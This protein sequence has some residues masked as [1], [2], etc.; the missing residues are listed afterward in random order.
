[1]R[2]SGLAAA[3]AALLCTGCLQLSA[4]V[5]IDGNGS[6]TIAYNI[7]LTRA[8]LAQLRQLAALG[9]GS[10]ADPLSEE[11]L[12]LAAAAMG[13]GVSVVSVTSRQTETTEGR[14]VVYA[15]ADINQLRINP[16]GL[17]RRGNVDARGSELAFAIA[18]T[19][20]AHALL[21]I[22]MPL[23]NLPGLIAPRPAGEHELSPERLAELR[24]MYAGM[25]LALAVE[26]AGRI[27]GATSL[28][29]DGRRVTLIDLDFDRLLA[30]EHAVA[31]LQSAST[32]DA[33][34]AAL[35]DVPGAKICLDREITIEFAPD[36]P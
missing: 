24:Q 10:A 20:D 21:R 7:S 15:F 9:G 27:V 28:F 11:R 4:V 6:G 17:Q 8:A 30:D 5:R 36:T 14:D 33:I 18:H 25:Q 1:M 3:A 12:R 13:P 34:K 29:V 35:K 22:T 19:P 2:G 16:P 32:I 26:P 23:P 31:R